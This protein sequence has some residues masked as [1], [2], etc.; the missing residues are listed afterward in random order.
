VVEAVTDT[1]MIVAD[2][3]SPS[4]STRVRSCKKTERKQAGQQG[5]M[6]LLLLLNEERD[7]WVDNDQNL[8]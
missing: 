5:L 6:L 3:R 1:T 4:R 8:R 7:P 2:G